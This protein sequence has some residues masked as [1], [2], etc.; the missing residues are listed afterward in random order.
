MPGKPAARTDISRRCRGGSFLSDP[1]AFRP[2]LRRQLP[3][4]ELMIHPVPSPTN[5]NREPKRLESNATHSKQTAAPN[6]NRENTACFSRHIKAASDCRPSAHPKN[7]NREPIRLETP[8]TPTKQSTEATSN[9]ENNACFSNSIPRIGGGAP[10]KYVSGRPRPGR[11]V[12]ITYAKFYPHHVS[13]RS[14]QEKERAYDRKPAKPPRIFCR[15]K[16][17]R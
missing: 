6:S 16:F 9:R 3:P 2:R 8:T 7:S 13:G 14:R 1:P 5:S 12:S 15:R 10:L 4:A 17:S 11:F